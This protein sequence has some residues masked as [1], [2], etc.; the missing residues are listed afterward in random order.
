MAKIKPHQN[1]SVLKCQILMQPILSALHIQLSYCASL[2]SFLK[3]MNMFRVHISRAHTTFSKL[4]FDL[5][6]NDG[7]LPFG[8][9]DIFTEMA[10]YPW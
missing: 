6:R 8:D 10:L 5:C 9:S 1:V 4:N 2:Y 3:T 7:A